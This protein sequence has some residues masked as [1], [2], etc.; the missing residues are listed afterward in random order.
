MRSYAAA[1]ALALLLPPLA[2]HANQPAKETAKTSPARKAA[3]RA[4]T[5]M[6]LERPAV[7]EWFGLY[8]LG[9]KAGWSKASLAVEERDGRKVLVGRAETSISA[10]VGPR[11][12]TR[13]TYDEKVYEAKPA[14][15]LLAFTAR[16]TGDGGER[17]TVGRCG[18]KECVVVTTA[19]AAR[20]ER[21]IPHPGE[22]ADDAD[23]PRLAAARRGTVLGWQ[24]EVDRLRPKRMQA[25]FLRRET[26][27]A[28]GVEVPVSIVE[29]K[30]IGP[31]GDRLATRVTIADDGRVLE[32]RIGDIAAK[33]EDE[34]SAHRLDKVDLFGLTRVK[35]KEALPQE[36]PATL[37]FRFRGL[38]EA[39]RAEDP[40][41]RFASG[42]P[43]EVVVTVTAAPPAAA[44]PARDAPR[45]RAPSG[46]QALLAPTP[47]IDS[48]APPI[49]KLAAE[50][51]GT[52]PGVYAASRKISSAVFER[53]E[54]AYGASRDRATEV[55]VS[56][57]GDCTEHTLLFT[58]L[59][60]AAGIPARQ[61]HGLV[62][63]R[64]EDDVPALYWHAWPEV[65]SGSEWIALDPTFGQDVAD[66]THI[67]LGRGAQVDTVSLLG[68]LEVLDVKRLR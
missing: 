18:P 48:D 23:A 37:Q 34:T 25:R 38:P 55:L 68:A 31:E 39:F 6:T 14:G 13:S 47:E 3:A 7:P 17:E 43:G 29:E 28:A 20:E 64:Y 59:A 45:G 4:P 26:L 62:F 36:V 51:V 32:I 67:A 19:G 63:A 27:A 9:Q 10:Q 12:V 57:K 2:A 44:D 16:R 60:R 53:L 65:L 41:Q 24:L 1:L 50:I 15:R 30:D 61:V 52:T 49:R 35:L 42:A 40:R 46:Q 21:R 66:A 56:G 8:V 22:T 5:V 11:S 33:A 58:A 54:K